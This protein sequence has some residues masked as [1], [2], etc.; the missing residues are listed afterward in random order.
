MEEE[1]QS[2][3]QQVG[4]A[5]SRPGSTSAAEAAVSQLLGMTG[6]AEGHSLNEPSQDQRYV[7]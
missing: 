3:P 6:L 2:L 5:I 7:Q 4:E 1:P